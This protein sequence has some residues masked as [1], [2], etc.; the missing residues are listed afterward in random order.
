MIIMAV[1]SG[2]VRTGIAVSDV[3][4]NFAFP[5]PVI[6]ERNEE[7]LIEKLMNCATEYG[8]GLIVLGLPK[9][10][11]GSLGPRA[12]ECR[13]LAEQLT[14][15]S[16]TQVILWDERCTTVSAHAA[17]NDTGLHGRGRKQVIDAVAAV[18]ILE[19]YLSYRKNHRDGE[20]SL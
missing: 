13:V 9:N 7:R 5:K 2:K 15:K 3:G 4:E 17:L 1:D 20:S 12:E 11:N 10:M 19:S 16:G 6:H 8:A 18:I 14:E